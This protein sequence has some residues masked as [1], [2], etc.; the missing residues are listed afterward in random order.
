MRRRFNIHLF[1][2]VGARV[3]A[4]ILST[5]VPLATIA[6]L[7][8]WHSY[9][10]ARQ[11]GVERLGAATSQARDAIRQQLTSTETALGLFAAMGIEEGAIPHFALMLQTLLPEQYCLFALLDPDGHP[12]SSVTR[13]DGDVRCGHAALSSALR[14]SAFSA[15]PPGIE[16]DFQLLANEDVPLI[17]VV[18]PTRYRRA[19]GKEIQGSIVV[20]EL[21]ELPRGVLGATSG[22]SSLSARVFDGMSLLIASPDGGWAPLVLGRS[23]AAAW[24]PGVQAHVMSRLREGILSAHFVESETYYSV[25]PLFRELVLVARSGRTD[26]ENHG[27]RL[28]AVRILLI[29]S[30]LAVEILLV[31][32]AARA[33]L[34]EPLERLS[35][36]VAEWRR[37]NVFSAGP[38]RAVPVE[39]RHLQRAFRR[40]TDRLSRHERQLRK[41]AR[42]QEA[43]IREI[44]HRIKNNLQIVASLL[45]LQAARIREP[46][47]RREFTLIRERVRTLATLHRYL[48]PEGGIA[49]LDIGGFLEELCAQIYLSHNLATD[50]RIKLLLEVD[51]VP[52]SPDQ[53]VPISLI[54]SELLN[55]ALNF[56]FP[57]NRSGTVR[58]SLK[59]NDANCELRIADDG[60]GFESHV[61]RDGAGRAAGLGLQLVRGFAR[62]MQAHV[63]MNT[64][65][66][67]TECLVR[68]EPVPARRLVDDPYDEMVD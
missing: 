45:N 65:E 16:S 41:A 5:T 26:E 43:L 55:N 25:T 9:S 52:I 56:A 60:I 48:Y 31:A 27:L 67:G 19:D 53:A 63:E 47:A 66:A 42:S 10:S 58:V 68:F 39:I 61:D 13:K 32:V 7:L 20:V 8:A 2:T 59:K 36:S 23:V 29:V 4:L 28:F 6:G 22:P 64:G 44:H 34:V 15:D 3:M 50:G 17:R 21:L 57:E 1:D 24:E 37:S 49:A 40:A 33:Y 18:S 11:V 38:S 30:L 51:A 12:V 46:A 54:V 62:Q 35:F 14:A